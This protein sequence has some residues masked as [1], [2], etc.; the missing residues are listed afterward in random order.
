M[1][2]TLTSALAAIALAAFAGGAA[3]AAPAKVGTDAFKI[4]S[5][6]D[7]VDLCSP[8][9]PSDPL[10]DDAINFCHG[11]VSGA[12]QYHQAEVNGPKGQAL[13]CWPDPPPTRSESIA[14]FVTW[15]RAHTQYMS[16]PAVETMFRFLTEKWPCAAP[17]A[18]K[19][20]GAAK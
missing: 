18:A 20:K 12:W 16:E 13:V 11:Y 1:R 19:K 2:R 14:M 8:S 6:Q 9:D 4:R 5:T 3:H 10:Y 17:A 7:L 15:A